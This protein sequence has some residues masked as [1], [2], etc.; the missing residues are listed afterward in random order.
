MVARLTVYLTSTNVR[1]DTDCPTCGWADL[2]H[3][4][5]H[6]LTPNGVTTVAE[7]I[8]CARCDRSDR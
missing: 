2:W 5:V 1:L 8:R 3:L 7:T 6:M 4:T